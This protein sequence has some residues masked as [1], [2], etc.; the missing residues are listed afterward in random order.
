[1]AASDVKVRRAE[2]LETIRGMPQAHRV[3]LRDLLRIDLEEARSLLETQKENQERD[4]L[5]G[6]C[7]AIR[8]MLKHVG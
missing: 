3:A 7:R 2:C 6:E 5:Q 1:M 8:G 4:R